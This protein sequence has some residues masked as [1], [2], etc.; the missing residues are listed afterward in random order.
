MTKK[1][2][3][4]LIALGLF[5]GGAVF[6]Q[7]V[8]APYTEGS[9]WVTQFVRTK[10]GMTDDYL[11]NLAGNWKK[12]QDELKRQGIVVSYHVYQGQAA[13]KEDWDLM[14]MVEYKN[15][16]AFDGIDGK[17]RAA[18]AKVIGGEETQRG[19]A[20]KRMEIREI[21]GGKQVQEIILK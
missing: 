2:F 18:A 6:G 16:A 13:N 9:V 4:L 20:V 8:V 19:G 11:K 7:A 1:L 5:G 17:F 12:V 3:V 15:H 10:P 14:M 21:L